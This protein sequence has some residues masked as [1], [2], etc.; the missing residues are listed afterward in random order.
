MPT[1]SKTNVIGSSAYLYSIT[2]YDDRARVVQTQQTN[3]SGG[4][5]TMVMQYSFSGQVLRNAVMPY[6][7]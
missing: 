4:R 5:D 6:K 2:F 1:G 7:E 3:N